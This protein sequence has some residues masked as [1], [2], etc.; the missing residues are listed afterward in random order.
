[1][2]MES[3]IFGGLSAAGGLMST[4]AAGKQAKA[5]AMSSILELQG[6][7]EQVATQNEQLLQEAGS[8]RLAAAHAVNERLEQL[9]DIKENNRLAASAAGLSWNGSE[10]VA[11]KVSDREAY[12]D[13]GMTE[14]N[15]AAHRRNLGYQIKMNREALKYGG[16]KSATQISNGFRNASGIGAQ[17]FITSAT[18]L[19]KY[20][21]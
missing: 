16:Y 1:M 3:L 14:Y 17:S 19:F 9:Q 10:R 5:N 7:Y 2:G 21:H 15:A 11:E 8:I 6:Q 13:V 18:T 12:K 20:A 4:M